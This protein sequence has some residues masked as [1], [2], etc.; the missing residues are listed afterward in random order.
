MKNNNFNL[1]I[2]HHSEVFSTREE[3]MVYLTDYYKPFSLEGEPVMVKYGDSRNP[4]AILAIGTSDA[5]PGGFFAIDIATLEDKISEMESSVEDIDDIN[6]IL[7]GVI[8][9]SGLDVDYNK[10]NDKVTYNP[11]SRDPIIGEATTIAEAIDLLSKYTHGELTSNHVDVNDT[12]S[13]DLT[14]TENSNSGKIITADVKISENG[15]DDEVDFNNNII[16]IKNDGIYAAAHLAYDDARNQLIFT[17]SG[18]KNNRFQNDAIVQKVNLGQHTSVVADNTNKNVNLTVVENDNV[19][20]ISAEAQ[21]SSSSDNILTNVDNKLFVDGRAS[22][23][24]Y[25]NTNVAA[26]LGEL[27][28]ADETL[29]T[30]IEEALHNA[31]VSGLTTDTSVVTVQRRSD[32]GADIKNDVRL[33]SNNSIVVANGG[34]EAN[35]DVA[36]DASLNKLTLKVGNVNKE[37]VLPGVSIIDNIT[38]DKT[39]KNIIITWKDGAQQT[40]IPVDDMLKTWIVNNDPNQPIVLTL[41]NSDI[42]QDKLSARLELRVG[43]NILNVEN[44][45]LYASESAITNK[46]DV[47]KN[48]AEAAEAQL[49]TDVNKKVE[50]VEVEKHDDLTYFINVDGTKVGEIKIP[51]DNYETLNSVTYADG[52]LTFTLLNNGVEKIVTA[53]VSQLIDT[54]TAGDGLV[55]EDKKFSVDIN[56]ETEPYLVLSNEGIGIFGINSKFDEKADK[57]EVQTL[58]DAINIIN[59]NESTEGSFAYADAQMLAQAKAYTD[60]NVQTLNETITDKQEQITTLKNAVDTLNGNEATE[61]SFAYGD[62]QVLTQSKAYT[63]NKVQELSETISNIEQGFDELDYSDNPQAKKFVTSVSQEDGK[64]NVVR[65]SVVSSDSS[66]VIADTADGGIDL[67]V[68]VDGVTIKKDQNNK[69]YVDKTQFIEY[70]G[71]EAIEVNPETSTQSKISLKLK[72]GDKVLTQDNNGLAA[73]I[74]LVSVEPSVTEVREE[75]KL[76]GANGQTLGET[77]K[78]YKDSHIVEIYLGEDID[79]VNPQTGEITKNAGPKHFLNYVYL[80]VLGQYSI[81]HVDISM[82]YSE[83]A[84]QDGLEIDSSNIVRLKLDSSSEKVNTAYDSNG[85]PTQTE[86]VLTVSNDGLKVSAIQNAINAKVGT[87]DSV[88]GSTIIANGKHVAVQVTETDGKLVDLSIVEDF[89]DIDTEQVQYV[90]G[91]GISIEPSQQN[92]TQKIVS[93]IS[94]NNDPIIEVNSNGIA[95]KEDAYWDCGSYDD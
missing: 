17:T 26:K 21:I 62:A 35:I 58:S 2:L 1:Q 73:S 88:V 79:T 43:D 41:D 6:E 87:L 40:I 56:N 13:V 49:R 46:V 32:G 10:I 34:L 11:D 48:R 52:T 37:V 42:R 80:N 51:E 61:G 66:V 28:A 33:S 18:M 44:G 83:N 36:V 16:G 38:Y 12:D 7:N 93:A 71:E 4:S 89:S 65:G 92:Q 27:S 15:N 75:Y 54:Y 76:M 31:N 72:N 74:E 78:I 70:V 64:I 94:P 81:V 86:S 91:N 24:K 69:L 55:L 25:Q 19:A 82:F 23:I 84:Y 63:D 95:T 14:I 90:A 60:S 8:N 67:G 45:K 20:Q 57:T 30:R 59:G 39:N 68:N 47:E 5:S 50:N 77:I 85:Q 29:S 22:N 9:A 53:D 3:A